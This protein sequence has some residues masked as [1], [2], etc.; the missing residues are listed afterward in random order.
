MGGNRRVFSRGDSRL[1]KDE[2][3]I[4]HDFDQSYRGIGK[5]EDASTARVRCEEAKVVED[6][7]VEKRGFRE[8]GRQYHF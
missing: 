8:R 2:T 4:F 6:V 7:F 3:L 5:E 1:P